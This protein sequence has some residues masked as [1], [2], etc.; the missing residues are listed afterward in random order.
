M[1]LFSKLKFLFS[2]GDEIENLLEKEKKGVRR[3]QWE[4]NKLRLKLCLD[5]KQEANQ[6]H[7]S[8]HNCDHCK[9]LAKLAE[10]NEGLT[11]DRKQIKKEE[12]MQVDAFKVWIRNSKEFPNIPKQKRQEL[13]EYVT[14][15]HKEIADLKEI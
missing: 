6:S 9:L 7:Y 11:T 5:H 1:K 4:P 8:S 3:H 12:Q 14:A 13:V 2:H 10:V 15:L